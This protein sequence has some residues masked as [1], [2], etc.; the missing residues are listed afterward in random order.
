MPSF[1]LNILAAQIALFTI[2]GAPAVAL[3]GGAAFF[4]AA[5]PS[6][7]G[8]SGLALTGGLIA[9]SALIIATPLQDIWIVPFGG[10]LVGLCIRAS[11]RYHRWWFPI[12]IVV[13]LCIAST[14]FAF[15]H[16]GQDN[17][18]P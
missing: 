14:I 11:Q 3:V 6:L 1:N 15:G 9:T 5:V 17:C 16:Y 13:A 8:T 2:F 10:V 18:Y 7:V 12:A 4:A